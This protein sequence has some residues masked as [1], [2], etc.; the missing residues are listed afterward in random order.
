MMFMSGR[1]AP[2]LEFHL[3]QHMY[4]SHI[5]PDLNTSSLFAARIFQQVGRPLK[6]AGTWA[7]EGPMAFMAMY[8][9]RLDSHVPVSTI[10]WT[11]FFWAWCVLRCPCC[12]APVVMG[13]RILL[14]LIHP[15]TLLHLNLMSRA[16]FIGRTRALPS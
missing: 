5:W 11:V 6:V 10:L 12:L 7:H 8:G 15:S 14:E 9:S 3:L 1:R 16:L 4:L 13:P 2:N